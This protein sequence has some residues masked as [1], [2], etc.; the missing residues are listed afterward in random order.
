MSSETKFINDYLQKPY[1]DF[2]EK[3]SMKVPSTITIAGLIREARKANVLDKFIDDESSTEK[4]V[5]LL[6]WGS[7][8]RCVNVDERGFWGEIYAPTL[9]E[10]VFYKLDRILNGLRYA[11]PDSVINK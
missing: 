5:L 10:G 7:E 4:T 3:Y 6:P 1:N 8:Y 9:E 11:A 2:L